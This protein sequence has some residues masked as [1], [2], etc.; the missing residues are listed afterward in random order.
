[1]FLVQ[2][3]RPLPFENL[4]TYCMQSHLLGLLCVIESDSFRYSLHFQVARFPGGSS[5][6][7]TSVLIQYIKIGF[8][9]SL[10]RMLKRHEA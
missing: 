6:L 2:S 1:M 5:N 8:S 3:N 10:N 9:E 7:Y 4:A